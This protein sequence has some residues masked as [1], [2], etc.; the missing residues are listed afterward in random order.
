MRNYDYMEAMK[1]DIRSWMND[2]DWKAE[3]DSTTDIDDL[4]QEWNDTL[5][6]EDCV[7]GNASGSYT[8]NRH[9][10]MENVIDNLDLLGEACKEFGCLEE[11]GKK[12]VDQEF[13]WMDVTI[14]CYLLGQAIEEVVEEDDI[15]SELEEI[16]EELESE[17]E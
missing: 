14:R 2:N 17:E 9:E 4:K 7:T 11:L 12:F 13:E 5:W 10:A 8:F 1:E 15:E 6:C 3:I 16:I